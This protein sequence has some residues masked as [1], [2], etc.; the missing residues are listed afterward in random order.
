MPVIAMRTRPVNR[1]YHHHGV[2]AFA[3]FVWSAIPAAAQCPRGAELLPWSKQ[4]E[5]REGWLNRRHALLLPMM[6]RHGIGMW[7]VVTE[8]FHDDPLVQYVAPPRPYVGD[9]DVF[10]FVDAGRAGLKK[11]A[12]TGYGEENLERFFETP[13]EP[14][15]AGD[16]LHE[17]VNQY[18]PQTIA[19]GIGG[20]RGVTR[21][22]TYDSYRWLVAALGTEAAGR[23]V[24]A[25]PL[26]E[27]YLDTRITEEFGYYLSAV[28]LTEALVC[29]ALSSEVITPGSTTVGDLRRWL[30]DALWANGVRTWFQPDVRV[31][32]RGTVNST[33]GP[34]FIA[35]AKESLV[36]RRR[37]V[38]HVDF[39][40]TYMGFDTDWQRMAYVLGEGETDA[41]EGLRRAMRN[42][43]ALQDVFVRAARP[44]R[45][46]GEVYQSTMAEMRRQGIDAQVYSHSIGNQ[47]HGIGPEVDF[48]AADTS[49]NRVRRLRANSYMSVELNSATTV[50]EWSGQKVVVML[51]DDAYL[52]PGGWRFFVPRQERFYLIR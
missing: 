33:F 48:R 11:F 39:G 46:T 7:I 6:R 28:R 40:L 18:H 45:P 26:I 32:R 42:T 20:E 35:P 30:Y 52:T 44:G 13:P 12:V 10:A 24:S 21:S 37:D 50:P 23:L 2:V 14:R 25:A 4:I 3:A 51:E 9:R 49:A 1:R 15:P 38:V 17:I 34:G 22:L 27:E 16:V 36:I 8:E 43:N 5:V 41:P 19:V 29:R 31:Q 47:G